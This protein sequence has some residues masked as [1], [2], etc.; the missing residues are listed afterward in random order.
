VAAASL[1]RGKAD[2]LARARRAWRYKNGTFTAESEKFRTNREEYERKE[3]GDASK[4]PPRAYVLGR[5]IARYPPQ[6]IAESAENAGRKMA[7]RE[8]HWIAIAVVA[9]SSCV[10]AC[11][12]T[13]DD[14]TL[15]KE[16][17]LSRYALC[18]SH[19]VSELADRPT[20]ETKDLQWTIGK[21]REFEHDA[22]IDIGEDKAKV[23]LW[24]ADRD[25]WNNRYNAQ[26]C[27]RYGDDYEVFTKEASE[28][29]KSKTTPH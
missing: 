7:P 15:G 1:E 10:A 5:F 24:Q 4:Q 16:V 20:N 28:A 22:G 21:V 26:D 18:I 14:M 12:R 27:A 6:M 25:F 9:F 2:S 8:F 11:K 17:I 13:N 19:D 3:V 23:L 29:A